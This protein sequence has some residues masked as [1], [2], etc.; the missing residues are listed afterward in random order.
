MRQT[1]RLVILAIAVS[2]VLATGTLS[3][4]YLKY[5]KEDPIPPPKT[6]EQTYTVGVWEGKL[7]VFEEESSFPLQL[8]DV[9]IASLPT[10]EQQRLRVGITVNSG[11]ELQALLEDYTS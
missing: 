8:Y 1:V 7:A 2:A 11:S 4:L 3:F 6:D 10:E 5:G 9:A